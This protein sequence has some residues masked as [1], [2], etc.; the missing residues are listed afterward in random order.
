MGLLPGYRYS[1]ISIRAVMAAPSSKQF[2]WEILPEL[3][4]YL[5]PLVVANDLLSFVTWVRISKKQS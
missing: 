1:E 5:G 2:V 4:V 3:R